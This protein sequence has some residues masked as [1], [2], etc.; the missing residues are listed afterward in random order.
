MEISESDLLELHRKLDIIIANTTKKPRKPPND[1]KKSQSKWED[2][3]NEIIDFYNI[4]LNRKSKSIAKTNYAPIIKLLENG[5]KVKDFK[6]VV[7]NKVDDKYFKDH[8][9][10]FAPTTLFGENFDKYLNSGIIKDES[11]IEESNDDLFNNEH[12]ASF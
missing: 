9:Q 8:P 6:Q 11:V 12:D 1:K 7:I 3:V 2:E 10:Y 5:Y 4:T